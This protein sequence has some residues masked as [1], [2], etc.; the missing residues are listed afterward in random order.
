[1]ICHVCKQQAV[2]QCKSCGKFYCEQH[3]DVYCTPCSTNI[4]PAEQA[5]KREV[6]FGASGEPKLATSQQIAGPRCYACQCSA[7]RACSKC[8]VFFCPQHGGLYA[9]RQ[10]WSVPL[11]E[12]CAETE[13]G[14][15]TCMW[16]Y[17]AFCV[18]FVIGM[19]ISLA[20]LFNR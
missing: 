14:W 17:A 10:S 16:I 2:G 12:P 15:L 18:I 20:R 5:I 9:S 3:G 1:M 11:C 6:E 7:N 19:I 8:G 4:K 13:R